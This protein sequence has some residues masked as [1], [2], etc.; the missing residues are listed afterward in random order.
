MC[1]I[2]IAKRREESK[3]SHQPHSTSAHVYPLLREGI[4][5]LSLTEVRPSELVAPFEQHK[6]KNSSHLD[7][8][9]K[10]VS[11]PT[12]SHKWSE[13]SE[14]VRKSISYDQFL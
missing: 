11:L 14:K 12:T 9:S 1:I 3:R 2:I 13:S 7:T 4:E 5:V 8:H 10:S 6:E